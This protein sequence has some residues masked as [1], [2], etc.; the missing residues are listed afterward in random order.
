M[1]SIEPWHFDDLK[2]PLKVIPVTYLI[3]VV[4]LCAQLTRDLLAIATCLVIIL[5]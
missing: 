1:P 2:W 4:T 5:H 3:T